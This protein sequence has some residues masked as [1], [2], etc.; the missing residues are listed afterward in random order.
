[1]K[2]IYEENETM[3]LIGKQNYADVLPL[4]EVKHIWDI[5]D[6]SLHSDRPDMTF[7]YFDIYVYGY[8]MGKRAERKRRKKKQQKNKKEG[9]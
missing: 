5:V 2:N 1:M 8:I 6:A 7:M 4:E 3:R 9:L